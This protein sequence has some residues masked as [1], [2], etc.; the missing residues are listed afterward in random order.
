MSHMRRSSVVS[1]CPLNRLGSTLGSSKRPVGVGG[2]DMRK[3]REEGKNER[4][5]K[6]E[7]MDGG[8]DGRRDGPKTRTHK[9]YHS[10]VRTYFTQVLG[11]SVYVQRT[12]VEGLP[13]AP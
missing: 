6:E 11:L 3:G 2:V 8:M 1:F 13:L 5:K 7:L 10:F 12:C 4:R 9:S